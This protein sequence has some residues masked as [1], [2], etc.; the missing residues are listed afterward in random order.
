[1]STMTSSPLAGTGLAAAT[2]TLDTARSRSRAASAYG[3]QATGKGKSV[4]A[5]RQAAQ[6]FVSFFAS[7]MM[8]PMFDGIKSDDM[9][10]GGVGEDTWKS[11]M[12]DQYGKEIAR[13]DGLGLTDQVMTAMLEAQEKA[14]AAA[15]AAPSTVTEG[16]E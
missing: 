10:G 9:F 13:Q 16:N 4:E 7:Q 1:M 2:E 15:S 6:E 8:Q 14:N 12:I 3:Q 5:T 11:M